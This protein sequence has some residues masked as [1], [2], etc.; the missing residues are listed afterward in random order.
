MLNHVLPHANK[1]SP[2]LH[3]QLLQHVWQ[4]PC[5]LYRCICLAFAQDA[6]DCLSWIVISLSFTLN[7]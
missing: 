3:E 6:A 4:I 5:S 7:C 2:E 1:C